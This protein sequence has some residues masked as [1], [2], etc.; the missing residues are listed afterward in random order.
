MKKYIFIALLTAA[1]GGAIYY[2]FSGTGIRLEQ[3]IPGSRP[4]QGA[5]GMPAFTG[6]AQFPV[7][8]TLG[9]Q[10][11]TQTPANLLESVMTEY[12]K[13]NCSNAAEIIELVNDKTTASEILK[14]ARDLVSK[15]RSVPPGENMQ[16][17]CL[18]PIIYSALRKIGEFRDPSVIPILFDIYRELPDGLLNMRYI[19][20]GLAAYGKDAIPYIVADANRYPPSDPRRM[21]YLLLM[22]NI[23]DREAARE[24]R[25]VLDSGQEDLS[26]A[27]SQSLRGLG[28]K[29]PHDK[30]L[31]MIGSSS[32]YV[33]LKGYANIGTFPT[34]GVMPR[35]AGIYGDGLSQDERRAVLFAAAQ[36]GT[37]ESAQFLLGKY[38]ASA[39]GE[40]KK[41][42][43]YSMSQSRSPK[44]R[45]LLEKVLDDESQEWFLRAQAADSLGKLTGD[46]EKYAEMRKT[47]RGRFLESGAK[48]S[49]SP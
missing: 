6:P 10:A 24:L 44:T 4:A 13:G 47:I 37:P 34:P 36:Q 8:L 2:L 26:A 22:E 38:R 46:R 31:A 28:E 18:A 20:S 12:G 30:S 7:P 40:E 23:R 17:G 1:I 41:L 11:E 32:E 42:I 27:A 21:K 14:I 5:P 48:P 43:L 25:G 35:L 9:V 45:E 15:A 3:G 49:S 33:R 16:A 39:D 19:G 29:T